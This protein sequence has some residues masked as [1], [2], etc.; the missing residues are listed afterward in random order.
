MAATR[1]LVTR[2]RMVLLAEEA[3]L[4]LEPPVVLIVQM[5]H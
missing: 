2:M 3:P 5:L 4:K 1:V